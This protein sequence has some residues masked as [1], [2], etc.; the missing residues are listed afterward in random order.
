MDVWVA[1][2]AIGSVAAAAVAAWAA[3]QSRASAQQAN[4]A[5][6]TLAR[7]EESRRHAEL[8]PRFRVISKPIGQAD[9]HGAFRLLVELVGP[10]ALE[11]L[12]RLTVTI[13]DDSHTRS[14]GSSI[15]GGPT[16]EQIEGQIW[17]S[18]RFTPDTGP[19][20][21]RADATGR[22]T[23]Y[24]GAIPVGESLVYQLEPNPPPSWSTG[25]SQDVWRQ[26]QGTILRL[27]L[28]AER[29]GVGSWRLAGELDVGDGQKQVETEIGNF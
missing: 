23:V 19:G 12:D 20:K 3:Y 4:Q 2:G 14:E 6:S 15:A 11:Q 26:E 21:A 8:C 29:D 27:A 28:L 10:Q 5:A 7:I 1:V 13:R 18:Y 24:E 17:G 9:Y 22:R 25:T 16:Q